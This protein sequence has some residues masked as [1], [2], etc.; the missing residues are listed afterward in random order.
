MLQ[1]TPVG[2]CVLDRNQSIAPDIMVARE[3]PV[4][5]FGVASGTMHF[6][7]HN[8]CDHGIFYAYAEAVRDDAHLFEGMSGGDHHDVMADHSLSVDV[9]ANTGGFGMIIWRNSM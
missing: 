8:V 1:A 6:G 5:S 2:A 9:A 4:A 3:P 7:G